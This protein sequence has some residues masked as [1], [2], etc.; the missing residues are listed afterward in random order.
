MT[1][2]PSAKN[3]LQP[4]D[5]QNVHP[6]HQKLHLQSAPDRLTKQ[7]IINGS[8]CKSTCQ[9]YLSY[10]TR[11]KKYCAEKNIIY[12]SPTVEQFLIF[13]TELF[14][15]GVPH[16]VII[17]AKSAVAYTLRTK[18]QRIPR[19]PSVISKVHLT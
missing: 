14:N 9:K 7:D 2:T 18:Y 6:R 19:H 4:Q 11:W 10:Q 3:L 13:F 8:L 5:P 12:D 15:Q 16:S 1:I 17:P